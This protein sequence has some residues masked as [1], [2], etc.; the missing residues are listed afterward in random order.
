MSI[1]MAPRDDLL[2]YPTGDD[3]YANMQVGSNG[4]TDGDPSLIVGD[5]QGEENWTWYTWDESDSGFDTGNVFVNFTAGTNGSES[6]TV[7]SASPVDYTG[8]SIDTISAVDIQAAVTVP[9]EASWSDITVEFY[10]GSTLE[11]TVDPTSGPSV[12]TTGTPSSPQQEQILTVTP[13]ESG[14]TSVSVS[15]TMRMT[16]GSG[17]VPGS[18]GMFCNIYILGS[19][20]SLTS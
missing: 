2:M 20:G 11:Q 3:L 4:N 6:L 19:H 8:D 16:A 12:N 10:N 7:G 1:Y 9:A 14:I 18:T 15:G 5:D 13:S 17:V